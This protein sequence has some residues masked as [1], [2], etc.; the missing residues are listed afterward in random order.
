MAHT[1]LVHVRTNQKILILLDEAI[2][3]LDEFARTKLFQDLN[4]ADAQ[5]WATGLD[6]QAFK[7]IPEPYLNAHSSKL[8]FSCI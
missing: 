7:N 3:H 2:A 4:D 5:V 1:K 6:E 8:I